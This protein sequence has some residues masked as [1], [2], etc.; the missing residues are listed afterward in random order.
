MT[1]FSDLI[2]SCDPDE[3]GFEVDSCVGNGYN[4]SI[5]Y[6]RNRTGLAYMEIFFVFLFI[7]LTRK[8][9]NGFVLKVR[10]GL[11]V[12]PLEGVTLANG[13][14]DYKIDTAEPW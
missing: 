11:D 5:Y 1:V 4:F 7:I 12:C 3:I 14:K 13:R 10:D 9:D 8:D 2:L 6:V